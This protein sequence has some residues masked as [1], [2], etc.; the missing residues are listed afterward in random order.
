MRMMLQ[1]HIEAIKGTAVLQSGSFQQAV[2][3]FVDKFKPEAIY[4]LPDDGMRSCVFV[5]DMQGSEQLP[6][7]SE[8]FFALGFEVDIRPCMTPADLQAGLAASGL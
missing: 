6:E 7:A 2:E 3:A 1:T 5:F 4:F 8:P